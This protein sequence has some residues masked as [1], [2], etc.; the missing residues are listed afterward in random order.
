MLIF[1]F[2]FEL[3]NIGIWL[4]ILINTSFLSINFYVLQINLDWD[5]AVK[6]SQR[7]QNLEDSEIREIEIDE[8]AFKKANEII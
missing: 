3:G 4:A 6:Q 8:E 7:R 5:D 1:T 2:Y